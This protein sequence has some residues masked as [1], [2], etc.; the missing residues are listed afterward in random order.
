MTVDTMTQAG[1]LA[2]I[3]EA[4]AADD[5]DVDR[6]DPPVTETGAKVT[7]L[8]GASNIDAELGMG[9][10]LEFNVTG[11]V[12]FAGEQ[13]MVDGHI[14]RLRKVRVSRVELAT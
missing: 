9:D 1:E 6:P 8:G 11:E 2:Q 5:G 7:F 14:R 3:A 13:K 4:G 10:V 12:V